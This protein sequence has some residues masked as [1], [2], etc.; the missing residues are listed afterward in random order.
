[1]ARAVAS[2]WS[3]RACRLFPSRATCWRSILYAA[4]KT[5]AEAPDQLCRRSAFCAP[6]GRCLSTAPVTTAIGNRRRHTAP[7]AR[8]RGAGKAR[9]RDARHGR[10]PVV[11]RQ[12]IRARA[13]ARFPGASGSPA[14]VGGV[15]AVPVSAVRWEG[16]HDRFVR[17]RRGGAASLAGD[18]AR[19]PRRAPT[20]TS[21]AG[22]HFGDSVLLHLLGR[23]SLGT[24]TRLPARKASPR[25]PQYGDRARPAS[26]DAP[27]R[28]EAN[29]ACRISDGPS[30]TAGGLIWSPA[31]EECAR[32]HASVRSRR[33]A[34]PGRLLGA[35]AAEITIFSASVLSALAKTS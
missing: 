15:G 25:T 4:S 17:A 32:N 9:R 35:Y 7:F 33:R 6:L 8:Q 1:M 19:L 5:G 34:T 13:E 21:I 14:S 26:R 24:I 30:T 11:S 10:A 28:S 3:G 23:S 2:A 18:L 29:Y 31:S 22:R 27:I 12:G 16:V 20:C